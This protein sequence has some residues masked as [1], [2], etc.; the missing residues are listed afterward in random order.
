MSPLEN[1]LPRPKKRTPV[2]WVAEMLCEEASYRKV[3]HRPLH[4][5]PMPS[6]TALVEIM[7]R[8]RAV[9]FPGYFGHSDITPENMRFHIGASLDAINKLLTDQVRRGYCFF[10]EMDR[11]GN[12][13]DC[14]E[15]ARRLAGDFLMRLPDIRELLAE[16]AQA[17]F[18][19]DPASRSPGE[20]IFCYPSLTALT[21]YR[22]A[23]ELHTLGVDLIPRIITEMAHSRT[24][25]DI[26]PGAT[27]GRR[28]FIDHGTGTVIGETC[29]IGNGVRLYQGVTLGAKSFPKDEQGMLV[30]GIARH[31]VVE[32]NVVVYSGA[33]V[34]GRVTIGKGSVIGGNVW[35]VSDVPPYSRIVQ[36]GPGGVVIPDGGGI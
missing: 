29:V 1:Q 11:A 17:A 34:L 31:P 5:E 7:E 13:Q 30:K 2:E 24:G 16:D 19:G 23:H 15:R 26:H 25:I 12:C 27:I 22:V 18:E 3:Y 36:Q 21:H 10:C 28:F 6:I 14:E 20:T 4:D 35:V 9:L 33:T 8:L 32:D